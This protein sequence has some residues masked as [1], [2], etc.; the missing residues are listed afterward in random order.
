MKLRWMLLPLVALTL[1][2][3]GYGGYIRTT[4][5]DYTSGEN[6]RDNFHV[7]L[8]VEGAGL[9]SVENM[10]EHLPSAPYILRVEVMGDL[11]LGNGTGQQKVKVVQVYAG[12]GIEVGQ[13]F[14][15]YNNSWR[16]SFT[17]GNSLGRGFVNVL[18]VGREYLVFIEGKIDTLDSRVPVYGCVESVTLSDGSKVNIIAPVFCYDHKDNVT[19]SITGEWGTGVAYTQVRDNEFFGATDKLI[20]AWEQLKAEMLQKYPRS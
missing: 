16:V 10:R 18:D 6:W 7:A 8:K 15:L 2:A 19:V 12:E 5:T 17:N 9:S 13:E 4:L 20:E 11:E 14:Y 3:A 1:A